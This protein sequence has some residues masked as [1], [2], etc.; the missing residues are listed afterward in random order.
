MPTLRPLQHGDIVMNEIEA[1]W[2]GYVG[3]GVQPM[4]IGKVDPIWHD[5]FRACQEI[6][7][8]TYEIFKPGITV[9]DVNKFIVDW[10]ER[11]SPFVTRP[12][13]HSRGLGDDAP[14]SVRSTTDAHAQWEIKE[15][16]VFIVKPT[17]TT[18]DGRKRLYWGDCVVVTPDGPRRL[19]KRP[20]DVI[21]I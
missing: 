3:Q 15:N 18:A 16:T 8:A 6:L 10:G 20:I 14:V 19:G 5:I 21:Q 9:G 2:L 17:V 1:R 7:A 12:L 13:F 4:F 11:N